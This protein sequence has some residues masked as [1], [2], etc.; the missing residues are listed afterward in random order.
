MAPARVFFEVLLDMFGADL[1]QQSDPVRFH[2][3]A[4]VAY[5]QDVQFHRGGCF[6][7]FRG[8]KGGFGGS[9]RD[10]LARLRT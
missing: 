3:I 10:L 7:A 8:E 5:N 6:L 2:V 4:E 9:E 1:S